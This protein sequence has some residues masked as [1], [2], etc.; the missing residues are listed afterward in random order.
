[1][2]SENRALEYLTQAESTLSSTG[3]VGRVTTLNN[4]GY[5][6]A[7]QQDYPRATNYLE[8]AI[9]WARKNG[10][11]TGEAKALSVLGEI[12]LESQNYPEA[13]A[14]LSSSVEIFES[15]RPGLRDEDKIALLETQYYTYGLL[16]Q[17]QI[18]SD[19][20]AE[21]LIAAERSRA[22][23]FVELL[24]QRIS[25]QSDLPTEIKT[26]TVSEIQ[27]VAKQR[28]ATLVTYSIIRDRDNRESNLYIWVVNPQGEITL[29]QLDLG[30][31]EETYKTSLASVSNNAR[32]AASGGLDLR[33]PRLEDFVVS[34]R[35]EIVSPDPLLNRRSFSFPRDAYKLLIEPIA[36][37]LPENPEQP[38]IFIPQGELFLVPFPALQSPDGKFLVERHTLQVAPSI[39]T[40][41]LKES[42]QISA[43][44]PA[45]IVGNPSPMPESFQ[46]LPGA[47]TEAKN[48]AEILQTPLLSGREATETT[49]TQQMADAKLIHLATHG[50]F[51][52]QQGLQSS[53]ALASTPE[54]SGFLTAEEI[55]DLK[56]DADLV[57][58]SA[59]N[60]GRGKITGDG[61]IGLSRSFLLA[62]ASSTLVSLWY[63]PDESTA[64]LMAQFYRNLQDNPNK[65]QSLRQAMITLMK[66]DPHPRNWAGFIL[67]GQ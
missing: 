64:D 23:S 21:A 37:L 51:D 39:Q 8:Q 24:A 52:D 35:G 41:G 6:Y 38:V 14:A 45:L 19:R 60:T 63:I 67:V 61:V 56:L 48:I 44:E 42:S 7:R 36:D 27:N 28:Q 49:V 15:L 9:A 22:R 12:N 25:F 5:Y 32:Q 13:E 54:E 11:R 17:T 40:L 34:F 33:K 20:P 53:L 43:T 58:L 29:R 30:A 47:E 16:Q 1:L 46:P 66:Q 31:I 3:G 18:A 57:V 2:G 10:D 59:C 65:A 62:G 55:L 26:P 50:L 4:L